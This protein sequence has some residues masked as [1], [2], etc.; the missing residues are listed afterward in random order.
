A[1]AEG[2]AFP[3]NLD[4]DQPV[5]G[6]AP[7]TQ[8]ELIHRALALEWDDETLAGELRARDRRRATA[9]GA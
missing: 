7:E 2:Y 3:T 1:S 8:A 5:G 4:H 6:P 9:D